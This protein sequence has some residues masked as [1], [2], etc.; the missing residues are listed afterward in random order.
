M[1]TFRRVRM[2]KGRCDG[3]RQEEIRLSRS[4]ESSPPGPPSAATAMSSSSV[5][6]TPSVTDSPATSRRAS[7]TAPTS[8]ATARCRDLEGDEEPLH[9]E[10][11]LTVGH[12]RAR[13]DIEQRRAEALGIAAPS[14]K[15][16]GAGNETPMNTA[17]RTTN[18][19]IAASPATKLP[20]VCSSGFVVMVSPQSPTRP[21]GSASPRR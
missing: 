13:G 18:R 4:H 7:V 21:R 14:P 8:A 9:R 1:S 3:R 2:P 10:R 20:S 19:A 5:V 16:A 17:P 6:S 12:T 15:P 11:R